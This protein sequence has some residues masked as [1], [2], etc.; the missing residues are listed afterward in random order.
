M[1]KELDRTDSYFQGGGVDLERDT[2][3]AGTKLLTIE[4]DDEVFTVVLSDRI[5]GP[6]WVVKDGA[7]VFFTEH[8]EHGYPVESLQSWHVHRVDLGSPWLE[9]K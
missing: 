5:P 7:L 8:G 1:K 9:E 4:T 2:F 6:G 3:P